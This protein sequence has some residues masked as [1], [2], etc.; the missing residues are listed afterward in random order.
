MILDQFPHEISIITRK[1]VRSGSYPYTEEIIET[2]VSVD[3]FMDTP[4]T[5]ESL[6]FHQM[7]LSVSRFLYVPYEVQPQRTDIIMYDA[8]EYEIIGAPEDQGGQH[9]IN[10]IPLRA[11]KP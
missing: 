7:E 8:Q 6:R 4:S 3:G 11:V 10:R 1:K 5:N 9:E 2:V